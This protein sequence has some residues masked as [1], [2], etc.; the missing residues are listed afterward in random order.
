MVI[1]LIVAALEGKGEWINMKFKSV[2]CKTND[3]SYGKLNKCYVKPYS[4]NVSTL[5][6]QF[7]IKKVLRAPIFVECKLSYKYITIYRQV[8]PTVTFDFCAVMRGDGMLEKLA[9]FVISLFKDSIPQLLHP[10]PF[11]TG[12][13]DLPNI[14]LNVKELPMDKLIP[15]GNVESRCCA[16][17]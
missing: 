15:T 14:S 8:Y 1:V 13:M 3:S 4:W 2:K 17:P 10:C 16:H 6:L 7:D 11:L 12:R 5:N 9:L